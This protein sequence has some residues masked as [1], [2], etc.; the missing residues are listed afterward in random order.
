MST[1][2]V[3]TRAAGGE[4]VAMKRFLVGVFALGAVLITS[5]FSRARRIPPPMTGGLIAY[6]SGAEKE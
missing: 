4:E 6:R 5:V 1:I 3:P 2:N